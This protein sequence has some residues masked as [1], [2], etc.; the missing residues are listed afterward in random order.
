LVRQW[1]RVQTRWKW[2]P[3]SK[4][5][6]D[7]IPSFGGV[8]FKI[9]IDTMESTKI[10]IRNLKTVQNYAKEYGISR[11]T[12]YKMIEEGELKTVYIDGKLYIKLND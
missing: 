8:S 9:K 7:G 1:F 5:W 4:K 3:G 11:P 12:V 6:L 10:D 2:E